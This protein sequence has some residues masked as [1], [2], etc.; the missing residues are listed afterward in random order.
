MVEYVDPDGK[1]WS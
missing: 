1:L